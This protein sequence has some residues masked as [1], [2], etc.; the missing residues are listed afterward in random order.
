VVWLNSDSKRQVNFS[1]TPTVQF[2]AVLASGSTGLLAH[3]RFFMKA[4]MSKLGRCDRRAT[5]AVVQ[6]FCTLT[7]LASPAPV[8]AVPASTPPANAANQTSAATNAQAAVP[9]SRGVGDVVKMLDAGVDTEVV[10]TYIENAPIAFQPTANEIIALH[11]RGVSSDLITAMLHRGGELR[12]QARSAQ[13]V[14]QAPAAPPPA[15]YPA[16]PPVNYGYPDQTVY[17]AYSYGDYAYGD[18]YP[19]YAVYPGSSVSLGFG[20]GWPYYGAGWGWPGYGYR[21]GWPSYRYGYGSY[22]HRYGGAWGGSHYGGP[23]RSPAPYHSGYAGRGG[24]GSY[25]SRYAG[26]GGYGSYP[27]RYAGH[28]GYGSR[29]S[30]YTG[31]GGYGSRPSG[32]TGHGGYG[33]RPSGYTGHGGFGS[34]P[35]SGSFHSAGGGGGASHRGR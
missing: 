21:S 35:A 29:P 15:A 18:A 7:L 19:D 2:P 25:P 1:P 22:G 11:E 30:G 13:P 23:Y 8:P 6:A 32:Y 14:A 4:K 33:S 12:A 16:A 26:R 24:Y 17:P 27:S 5:V 28:G 10:K 31:H 20:W 3:M 9:F 34:S